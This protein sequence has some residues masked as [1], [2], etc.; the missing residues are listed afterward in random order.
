MHSKKSEVE[1]AA[2]PLDALNPLGNNPP[3]LLLERAG[4]HYPNSSYYYANLIKHKP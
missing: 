4:E 2:G 3:N 1:C